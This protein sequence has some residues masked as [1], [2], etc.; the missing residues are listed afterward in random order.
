MGMQAKA[1]LLKYT[2]ERG[3]DLL[4]VYYHFQFNAGSKEELSLMWPILEYC[5]TEKYV[6]PKLH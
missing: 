4:P 2:A 1:K 3:K 6:Y 5:M